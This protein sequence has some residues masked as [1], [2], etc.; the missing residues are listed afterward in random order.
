MQGATQLLLDNQGVLPPE[1]LSPS[2][3]S[4]LSEEPSTS[5]ESAGRTHIHT[6]TYTEKHADEQM[7]SRSHYSVTPL[8]NKSF[9]KSVLLSHTLASVP[10]WRG[11]CEKEAFNMLLIL[12]APGC[13]LYPNPQSRALMNMTLVIGVSRLWEPRG[14]P[15]GRRPGE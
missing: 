15:Y 8:L 7:D 2:P 12:K 14:G 10:L 9:K 4:S 1:L 6:R 3:P 11:L 5:S 13:H